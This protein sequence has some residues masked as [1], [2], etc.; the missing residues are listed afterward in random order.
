MIE[1]MIQYSV[2]LGNTPGLV[3]K[4]CRGLALAK[5]NIVALTMMDSTEHGVLRVVGKDSKK[6]GATL[7]S[8]NVPM[9]RTE[10]LAVTM[11]NRPG[12]VADV[13]EQL[14]NAKIPISYMYSTTGAPGGKAIGIFK[15]TDMTKARK[16]LSKKKGAASRDMKTKL[17]NASRIS[18][19]RR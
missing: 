7:E 13:C 19:S 4:I 9:T 1:E 8:L 12:A 17:R 11:P 16:I 15:V 2:F 14:S 18:H 10:V 6:T 3:G 5:I